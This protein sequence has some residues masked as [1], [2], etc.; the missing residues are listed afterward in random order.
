MDT[1]N[2]A[3]AAVLG[4]F[5]DRGLGVLLPFGGGHHYDLV[6]ALPSQQ[7]LRVQCKAGRLRDGCILFN[8]CATD[9]GNG[10]RRYLGVADL[11]GIHCSSLG[12][13]YV[14]PVAEV[15]TCDGRL[16]VDPARNNQKR[17]IRFAADYAIDRW[18]VE[19]F[20]GIAAAASRA[21]LLKAA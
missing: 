11:F 20:E 14:V 7:F 4:A 19:R 12:C 9:H 16:R 13:V 5:I 21:R 6:I 18:D 8:G 3:E 15:P 17:R 2:A 10:A 1:G